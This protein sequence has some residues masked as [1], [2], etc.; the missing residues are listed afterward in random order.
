MSLGRGAGGGPEPTAL[1]SGPVCGQNPSPRVAGGAGL[2]IRTWP[3]GGSD[4]WRTAV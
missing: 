4:L 3:E 1:S 2:F